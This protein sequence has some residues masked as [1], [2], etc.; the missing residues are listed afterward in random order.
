MNDD[1]L[2][3]HDLDRDDLDRDDAVLDELGRALRAQ[4]EVPPDVLAAAKSIFTWRTVNAELAALSY[5]SGLSHGAAEPAG[6]RGAGA[7]RSLSFDAGD[8]TVEVDVDPDGL[9]GLVVP[10]RPGRVTLE[11]ASGEGPVATVDEFGGF[12][13]SPA[14]RGRFRL[15]CELGPVRLVTDWIEPQ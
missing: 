15:R 7:V 5:D 11:T 12:T 4:A 10:P 6:V 3:R 2:D 8:S 9:T 13:L 14:P 1:D